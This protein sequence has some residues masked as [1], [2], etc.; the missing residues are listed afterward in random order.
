MNIVGVHAVRQA[1]HKKIPGILYIAHTQ[2]HKDEFIALVKKYQKVTIEQ[3]S[4]QA[5]QDMG[6]RQG[7]MFV[8]HRKDAKTMQIESWLD[9]YA[10]DNAL[11]ALVLDHI[12]DAQNLGA[13]FRSAAVFAIDSV[14]STI[15]RSAPENQFAIKAS[16]GAMSIVPSCKVSNIRHAIKTLKKHNI[17]TYALDMSGKSINTY[18]LPH[19]VAFVLGNEHTGISQLVMQECDDVLSIPMALASS[20]REDTALTIDSLNVSVSAGIVCYKY[21]SAYPIP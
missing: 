16:S 20:H 10:D 13:I 19:R 5:L 12:Q 21:R 15:K 18:A 11:C 8:A 9:S 4:K 7:I 3:K 2:S 14:I 17:W 1:L 6:A